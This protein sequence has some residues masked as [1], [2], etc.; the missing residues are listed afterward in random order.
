MAEKLYEGLLDFFKTNKNEDKDSNSDV[1]SDFV[2]MINNE[3]EDDSIHAFL[4]A[5][6]K[7]GLGDQSLNRILLNSIQNPNNIEI[8][9]NEILN[10]LY[11]SALKAGV[12]F[13]PKNTPENVYNKI[14]A[15]SDE[16]NHLYSFSKNLIDYLNE[17]YFRF[18][19]DNKKKKFSMNDVKK[20]CENFL[21]TASDNYI[22]SLKRTISSNLDSYFSSTKG[23]RVVDNIAQKSESDQQEILDDWA[24]IYRI[25]KKT[26][27]MDTDKIEANIKNI[28]NKPE[29]VEKIVN[30]YL[31]TMDEINEYKEKLLSYLNLSLDDTIEKYNAT[32]DK[33]DKEN[34]VQNGRTS[35]INILFQFKNHMADKHLPKKYTKKMI[36]GVV[37]TLDSN[38]FL[39]KVSDVQISDI[40]DYDSNDAKYDKIYTN[41]FNSQTIS[42]E[43]LNIINRIV[44]AEWKIYKNTHNE[45]E[46]NSEN[47][48]KARSLEYIKKVKNGEYDYNDLVNA[49]N[50]YRD[51]KETVMKGDFETAVKMKFDSAFNINIENESL[52]TIQELN[53]ILYQIFDEYFNKIN[54]E[55]LRT[56]LFYRL[57]DMCKV[58]AE[59]ANTTNRNIIKNKHMKPTR[60]QLIF[61]KDSGD[62]RNI[63]FAE[64]NNRIEMI[65]PAKSQKY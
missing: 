18:N 63:E 36:M 48:K 19:P 51:D 24:N 21:S 10:K 30:N 47:F 23:Q 43:I 44:E 49:Y 34:I 17:L 54:D 16:E 5:L 64:S 37:D 7:Y 65:Q 39:Q 14:E 28:L 41:F 55:I 40:F 12:K 20:I 33:L 22:D 2:N 9:K 50:E 62:R 31:K 27:G 15:I 57:Y 6:R 25:T 58:Y 52:I 45:T 61:V 8:F 59:R 4:D 53:D 1:I 42:K 11:N 3:A 32:S 29:N 26:E 35:L 60:Y 46:Q 13:N 38:K 56:H